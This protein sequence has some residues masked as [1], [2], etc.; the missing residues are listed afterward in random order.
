MRISLCEYIPLGLFRHKSSLILFLLVL[1][2]NY[3]LFL[4]LLQTYEGAKNFAKHTKEIFSLRSLRTFS[5][6]SLRL[7]V[8]LFSITLDFKKGDKLFY[9]YS[10]T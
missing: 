3:Y 1:H 6:C 2:L 7:I 10:P 8:F 4:I 9:Y 5:S